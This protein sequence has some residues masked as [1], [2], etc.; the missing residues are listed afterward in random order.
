[1]HEVNDWIRQSIIRDMSEGVIVLGLDGRI[2]YLN[3]AAE[4]ILEKTSGE[5]TGRKFAAAFFDSS[6][7]D[8]FNQTILDAVYDPSSKHYQLVPYHTEAKTRQLYVMTSF[9]RRDGENEGIIVVLSD[10]TELAELK[11]RHAQQISDL[12]DSLVRALSTA[13][14]ARS[15]YNANH[16]RH[17]VQMGTAFLD[18]LDRTGHPWRFARTKRRAFLMSVWLHDVGKLAVSLSVMDKAT[19]LGPRLE[20]IET[21]FDKMHLLD[22]IALLEGRISQAEW[23]EREADRERWMAGILRVNTCGYLS[24][25]D[26]EIIT[27]LAALRYRDESGTER[28][29]LTEEE[30]EHLLIRK[31]TLT[32]RERAVMQSHADITGRILAQV[33]FPEDYAEVPLWAPA[34]HELLNGEGY[35]RHMKNG[36]IPKEVRL[37]TILDLFEALTAK[38]RPYKM[39][40]SVGNALDILHSM[41]EEGSLDGE[42]LALFEESRAWEAIQ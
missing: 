41:V 38:D 12:M 8:E 19:R 18:W 14:D 13:I 2:G 6:E 3:P 24:D 40:I 9:L 26:A 36:D 29:V 16:T 23:E 34:H 30:T 20:R 42:I 33:D 15:R 32:D 22:R 35:P 39:S 28:P 31:G 25:E 5:L 37:L 4:E 10:M 27:A 11:N 21:R 1:M 7:N 17:M